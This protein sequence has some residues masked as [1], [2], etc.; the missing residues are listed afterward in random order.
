VPSQNGYTRSKER[1]AASQ[2]GKNDLHFGKTPL[3]TRYD[4]VS[5]GF[6]SFAWNLQRKE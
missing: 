4:E 2:V 3:A 6:E 1:G 5:S